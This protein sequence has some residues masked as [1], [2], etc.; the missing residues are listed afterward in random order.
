MTRETDILDRLAAQ[1]NLR[2]LKTL[3]TQGTR[4]CTATDDGRD[5]C[6][7]SSNDYLG[8]AD[9]TLQRAFLESLDTTG[10]YLLGN[11]S[12]RLMTGNSPAYDRLETTLARSVGAETALVLGSG[13]AVNS[14]VL[15]AVTEK[16]DLI[17]AD[18]LVHASLIDGLRLC[19][20]TEWQ[21][22]RHNDMDHLATLLRKAQG[23]SYQ[24]IIVVTESLFSMDGDFA[25]LGTLAELQ[26]QYGFLLYLDEAH[27]FGVYGPASRPGTGLLAAYNAAH[28]DI[29]LRAEYHVV[30]FGKALASVGA[31]LICSRATK[32][33]LVNRMRPL[34]FS[35]ALPDISLEWTRYLIERLAEFEPRRQQLHRLIELLNTR[36]APAVPYRSQIIPIMAGS[37]ENALR[38]AAALREAGYWTTAIR[39]PTVPQGEARLRVSLCANHTP[40]E[41]EQFATLCRQLG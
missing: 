12:S 8:L 28:P 25:P 22:F 20:G 30:T 16:G 9:L 4:L 35:T 36:L 5:Y 13:F 17:L 10:R 39:H 2:S 23:K 27:S 6:N 18:K 1:G 11:P 29:P 31:A 37:N 32:E 21:R 14:G 33:L 7:L 24:R 26:Q 34:I 41:I 40:T 19:D 3:R 15:P 38:M